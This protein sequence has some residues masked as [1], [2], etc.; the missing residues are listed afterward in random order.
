MHKSEKERIILSMVYDLSRFASVIQRECP[1]FSLRYASVDQAFGVEV[2]ELYYSE[3]NARTHNIPRYT[4]DLLAGGDHRHRDDRAVLQV[5]RINILARDGTEKASDVPAILQKIP[6]IEAYARKLADVI[7]HKNSKLPEYIRGD[8]SHVNLIVMDREDRL[9]MAPPETLYEYLFV[10]EINKVLSHTDFREVYLVTRVAPDRRI[11]IPLR[12]VLLVSELYLFHGM[13]RE[14]HPTLKFSSMQAEL[15]L[16][17]AFARMRGLEV[18]IA[19]TKQGEIELIL[20]NSGVRMGEDLKIGIFDYADF[21]Q[22]AVSES[23]IVAENASCLDADLLHYYED[24]RSRNTFVCGIVFDARS[25]TS[26]W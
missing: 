25:G 3:S 19:H 18:G 9:H 17:A 21:P 11:C 16:F 1:D 22:P 23:V 26:V 6:P 14:R 2:T 20:G 4:T 5:G 24:Y 8:L 12:M 15:L 7:E 10:P 13:L